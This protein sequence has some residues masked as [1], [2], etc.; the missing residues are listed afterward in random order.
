MNY[1]QE[2][3]LPYNIPFTRAYKHNEVS[4][5]IMSLFKYNLT[6]LFGRISTEHAHLIKSIC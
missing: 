1:V 5:I 4:N 6:H 3:D 2:Y